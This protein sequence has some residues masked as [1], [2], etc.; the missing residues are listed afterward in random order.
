MRD[1]IA[2]KLPIFVCLWTQCK[3]ALIALLVLSLAACAVTGPGEAP[4]SSESSPPERTE[5]PVETDEQLD[6]EL[7]FHVLAAERLGAVGDHEEALGH[8][9]EAAR[10][11]DDPEL[12]RQ[13]IS[14]SMRLQDWAAMAEGA[15]RW[16]ELAPDDQAPLQYGVLALVNLGQIDEATAWLAA[17][18]QSEEHEATAWRDAMLLLA[19][20]DSDEAAL[21]TLDQLVDR[22]GD[23]SGRPEVMANRSFLFWQLGRSEEALAAAMAAVE[24]GGERAEFV[25]AAQ[26]AAAEGDLEAALDLYR[27]ARKMEPDSLG[28]ALSEAEVLRQLE[29][30]DE[31][32]ALLEGMQPDSEVLY[33]LGSYLYQAERLDEASD[34]WGQLAAL[35]DVEDPVHHAFLVAFLAEL[36]DKNAEALAWYEKVQSGPSENRALLRRAILEA[37]SG[38]L[39][40][41]R[42]LLSSVRMGNDRRLRSESYLIEADILREA[43]QPDEAV[44]LLSS[45]LREQP[46]DISLL[47]TRAISAV[48]MDDLELAEQDFRRI[49]QIDDDNAMALNALGYTL[50]DRTDRHQEAY[51]L[52]RRALELDPESPPIL[53]S[54]GWVYFRLGQPERALPYLERALAGEDNPE[55]AAHLGEVLLA[56]GREQEARDVF[57]QAR[58]SFP[59]D[60]YLADTIQRL[61]LAE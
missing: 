32:V 15:D 39:L 8:F 29:R 1:K 38:N 19:A 17:L 16:R 33:T 51:R 45:A 6:S 41:A 56:L 54:M 30:S 26:L 53:D 11:S 36:L 31:A 27:R 5:E 46:N 59:E 52:I 42:N 4:E 48:S 3:R 12:A 47:Y 57:D 40:A 34:V 10:L 7:L 24:Q 22:I 28:L 61:G 50:T 37:D 35:E 18:I 44:R 14:M 43:G 21:A 58:E 60:D 20:A 49:L 9:L 2:D 55:I 13:V 25:W 23:V